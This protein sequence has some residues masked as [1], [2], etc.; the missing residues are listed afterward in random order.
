MDLPLAPR[1][2]VGGLRFLVH[3]YM[4]Q[5]PGTKHLY[6]PANISA[7]EGFWVPTRSM[8]KFLNPHEKD[9]DREGVA[10]YLR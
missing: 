8:A 4:L 9:R 5:I 1:Q 2:H 7:P 6:P 10:Y 3:Y